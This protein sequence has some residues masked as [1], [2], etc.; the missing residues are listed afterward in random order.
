MLNDVGIWDQLY[1]R[2]T[3]TILSI[4]RFDLRKHIAE[5]TSSCNS[6][7]SMILGIEGGA[8][9]PQRGIKS[10]LKAV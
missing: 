8:E 1:W 4:R 6:R 2:S 7:P 10:L 3:E 5:T 9:V